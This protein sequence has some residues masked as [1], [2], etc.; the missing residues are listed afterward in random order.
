MTDPPARGR[1]LGLHT[2]ALGDVIL[3]AR[4]LAAMRGPGETVALAAGGEKAHLL[5]A[6]GVVN[7]PLDG[8][9]LPLEEL[10]T[11][12]P[13]PA[14]R[15]PGR[16]RASGRVVTCLL[17]PG[18][19][20]EGRLATWTGARSVLSLPIRPPAGEPRHLL[21]VW[22]AAAGLPQVPAP[23][24]P[25]SEPLRV[26]GRALL[27]AAGV[28]AGEPFVAMHVGAGAAAKCWP[29]DR[30]RELV[31]RAP[32]RAVLLAGP[33]ELERHGGTLPAQLAGHA[34]VV[35]P[36]LAAL[37]GL[38][39]EARAFVGND[40]GPAHLA[41]AVGCPTLA[42][43]GPTCPEQFAP[44]G[45]RVRTIRRNPLSALD[46][47]SVAFVLQSLLAARGRA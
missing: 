46:V 23:Q 16:L 45:P 26:A 4:L 10:F 32:L 47:P 21:D 34:W 37:A 28:G 33:A 40:S 1:L 8:G 19:T 9:A 17:E 3:F 11:P 43:F 39:A 18:S 22:A 14:P 35:A 2:G 5:A 38:L 7:E 44:R 25:V 41:A 12:E 36:P 30:F 31:G 15:L 13:P 24:W 20:G 42:L 29:L 6:L 27:S